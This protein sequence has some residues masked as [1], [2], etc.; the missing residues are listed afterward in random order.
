M[1]SRYPNGCMLVNTGRSALSGL[2][3]PTY[4]A[5]GPN[6]IENTATS[7]VEMFLN[8]TNVGQIGNVITVVAVVSANDRDNFSDN[9]IFVSTYPSGT[10]ITMNIQ[11]NSGTSQFVGWTEL[12]VLDYEGPLYL[13]RTKRTLSAIAMSANTG[14]AGASAL[15]GRGVVLGGSTA[16]GFHFDTTSVFHNTYGA[17]HRIHALMIAPV[18]STPQGLAHL[19]SDPRALLRRIVNSGT[20]YALDVPEPVG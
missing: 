4:Y 3:N 1:G 9:L 15:N 19:T 10:G 5:V 7:P 17:R 16:N 11:T 12:G 14:G 13:P 6:Y 20:P 8:Y 18:S 2:P